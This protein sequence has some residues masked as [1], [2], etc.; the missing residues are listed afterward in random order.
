MPNAK[1]VMSWNLDYNIMY[2]FVCNIIL[3]PEVR[4]G[5]RTKWTVQYFH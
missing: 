5:T 3:V 1:N 2:Y 4:D